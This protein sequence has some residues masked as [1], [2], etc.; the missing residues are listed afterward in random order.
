MISVPFVQIA[1]RQDVSLCL[2]DDVGR[3]PWTNYTNVSCVNKSDHSGSSE[4]H[5]M[6]RRLYAPCYSLGRFLRGLTFFDTPF[7]SVTEE[8]IERCSV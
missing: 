8:S 4:P 6:V 1:P 2:Y 3:L 7:A 5:L